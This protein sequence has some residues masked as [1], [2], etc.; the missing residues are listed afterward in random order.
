MTDSDLMFRPAIELAAMVRSG[1]ISS[2]ELVQVSLSRIAELDPGINAFVEVDAEGALAAAG[3]RR[4]GGR[5]AVRRRPHG[6]QEQ[7]PRDQACG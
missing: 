3:P 1:E 5:A 2:R 6:D 4:A 7:P